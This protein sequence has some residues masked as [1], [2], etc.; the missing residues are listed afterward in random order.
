M[1]NR[2]VEQLVARRAHNPKV[3]GSSPAAATKKANRKRLAF[4]ISACWQKGNLLVPPKAKDTSLTLSYQFLYRQW[5]RSEL[6]FV[7]YKI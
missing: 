6:K 1:S 2:G 5:K 3:V 4:I 7:A